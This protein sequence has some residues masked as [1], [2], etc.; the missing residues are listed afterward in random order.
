[1]HIRYLPFDDEKPRKILL[2]DSFVLGLDDIVAFFFFAWE[3]RIEWVLW[4]LENM[5]LRTLICI[6]NRH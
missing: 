1:M 4:L 5:L 6:N 3:A 2:A